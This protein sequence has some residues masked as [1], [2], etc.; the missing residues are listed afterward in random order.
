MKWDV[1]IIRIGF[2]A[3]LAAV[4]FL[5]NPFAHTTKLGDVDVTTRRIISAVVGMALAGLMIA[6]EMRVR[7]VSLK[8]L[9]GAAIGSIVGIVGAFLIGVLISIQKEAAVSAETQTF[10]TI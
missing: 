3:L 8:K 2:V 4:G 10:L 6:F 1:L 7:Q 5:L 9:I